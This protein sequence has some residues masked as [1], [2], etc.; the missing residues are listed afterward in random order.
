MAVMYP[1]R[2]SL[3]YKVDHV[4]V[5]MPGAEEAFRFCR[6]RLAL[7]VAWSFAQ[8]GAA[9]TGG[10]GLGNLN[11]E[12]RNPGLGSA[13][14]VI[15]ASRNTAGRPNDKVSFRRADCRLRTGLLMWA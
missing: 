13:Q 10:I 5:C 8:Y 7:P 11:M 12:F 2:A 14:P 3:A 1:D 4:G 9:H 6:D 15:T